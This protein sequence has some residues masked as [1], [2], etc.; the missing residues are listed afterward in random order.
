M[1]THRPRG[2][3]DNR[4]RHLRLI[5]L[6]S[7]KGTEGNRPTVGYGRAPRKRSNRRSTD[8]AQVLVERATGIEP[9]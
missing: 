4:D 8:I 5:G 2:E 3:Y 9:A 1:A 6:N 7:I